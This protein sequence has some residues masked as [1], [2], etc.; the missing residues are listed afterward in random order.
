VNVTSGTQRWGRVILATGHRRG[1]TTW[2]GRMLSLSQNSGYI[3]EPLTHT[4]HPQTAQVAALRHFNRTTQHWIL[5]W[6]PAGQNEAEYA[7]V[8]ARQIEE[9]FDMYF[10]APVGTLIIKQPGIEHLPL[11]HGVLQP[12]MSVYIKRHPVAILNSYDKSNLYDAWNTRQQF[13]WLRNDIACLR[14]DLSYMLSDVGRDHETQVLCMC[15]IAHRL[16]QDRARE[17]KLTVINY[18]DLAN[19]GPAAA[20]Q[21]FSLLGLQLSEEKVDQLNRLFSPTRPRAGFLDTEKDSKRRVTAYTSELAPWQLSNAKSY[22]EG[23]G[24]DTLV[25]SQSTSARIS[26]ILEYCRREGRTLQNSAHAAL[27]QMTKRHGYLNWLGANMSVGR[28]RAWLCR[29]GGRKMVGWAHARRSLTKIIRFV[30]QV[31]LKQTTL[32]L[33]WAISSQCLY[34]ITKDVLGTCLELN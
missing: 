31:G 21:L 17:G 2:L 26:G 14:P 12:E 1:G 20:E 23:I 24:Y 13:Q 8:V 27:S 19:G 18:E 22:L 9:L 6:P 28:W 16:A 29:R 5:S 33:G 30:M 3:F 25:P 34:S 11:L 4:R 7:R 32:V 10:S 15:C